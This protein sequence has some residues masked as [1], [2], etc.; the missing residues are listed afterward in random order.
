MWLIVG[1]VPQAD[2]PLTF[3]PCSVQG[4]LLQAGGQSIPVERGTAALAAAAWLTCKARHRLDCA[5]Y[6]LLAGDT[7]DGSGSRAVYAW[8]VQQ[9]T[10]LVQHT[11]D[12]PIATPTASRESTS[13]PTALHQR[14]NT[15]SADDI[16][17]AESAFAADNTVLETLTGITFHYLFPDVDWHNRVLLAVQDLPRP[18]LLVADA[19]FMYVA[20]MSGY[21][22]SYDLFTPDAGEMAFLADEDAP[23]PFYTRGFLLATE[24]DI[25]A[26]IARA[27]SHGNCA[28]HLIVKGSTDHVVC[29]QQIISS[30]DKPAL[31]AMEA[32][33]GTGDMVTGTVTGLLAMGHPLPE[34]CQQAVRLCRLL[35]QVAKPTP[36]TQVGELL[37]ERYFEQ[38]DDA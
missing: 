29:G 37:Q 16:P 5:P 17:R 4:G 18:P 35:A 10:R 6:V 22:D 3:G 31:A 19:G 33:G 9:L 30:I 7:G 25:P 27:H 32:I 15:F 20:K 24:D 13:L 38:L 14:E 2:F 12:T 26:L 21:A 11:S 28:R 36:A 8:L 23:H 1:T 34:A